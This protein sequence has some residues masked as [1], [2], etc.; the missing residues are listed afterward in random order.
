MGNIFEK[1][2]G[3]DSVFIDRNLVT[4]H[5]T[6]DKLPFR[7]KQ[8]KELTSALAQAL[9]AAKPDNLFLYG[10]TGTG[11]TVTAKFVVKQLLEYAAKH[12][13]K[14]STCY[15]NCRN[16]TSKYKV[17]LKCCKEFYPEESFLGFSSGFVFEKLQDYVKANQSA[18]VLVLDEIDK[19]KDLDDMVYALTRSNDELSQGSIS[20]IGISNNLVFKDRLD[21]RTKSALCEKEMVFPPYNAEELK[22]ILK[23]RA[24]IAFKPR[25]VSASAINLAAAMAAKESGDARTA[26]TLL[27]RAGEI[28][29]KKKADKVLD[30]DVE[31]ARKK[32]EDEIII[33]M[34]STLPI[35]EK[36]VLYAIAN[37]SVLKKGSPRLVQKDEDSSLYSGEVYEEYVRWAKKC[38]ENVVSTRWYREYI[39]ELEL[40]GLLITTSSGAGQRGQTTFI[41]LGHDAKKIRSL[42]DKDL[43]VV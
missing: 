19:V 26:V 10:R 22:E 23:Q 27:L 39:N 13:G 5:Y 33:N 30:E 6:P 14:V 8:I 43:G 20:V 1:E 25:A 34:V 12:Q 40:Y 24:Q 32:V 18:V 36:L 7:E 29:D 37:L 41:K 21:A 31:K 35:Q 3:K 38:K 16:Y 17:F 11:K 4:P 42:L 2:V 9:K 28:A 15:V